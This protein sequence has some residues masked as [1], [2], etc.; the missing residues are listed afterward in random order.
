MYT[1][2][3]MIS[4]AKPPNMTFSEAMRCLQLWMAERKLHP[5]SFKIAADVVGGFELSFTSERD[6]LALDVFQWPPP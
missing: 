4:L 1:A 2:S 3:R 6:A 5:S